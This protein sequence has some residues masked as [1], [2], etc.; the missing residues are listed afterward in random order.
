M[1]KSVDTKAPLGGAKSK[2][3]LRLYP[4]CSS[5]RRLFYVG[6]TH[7]HSNTCLQFHVNWRCV[8]AIKAT[9]VRCVDESLRPPL[10]FSASCRS[11]IKHACM[12]ANNKQ[13][14]YAH[15]QHLA[16][17][18]PSVGRANVPL[19]SNDFPIPMGLRTRV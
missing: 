1:Y 2:S 6:R 19:D 15:L 11:H 13:L 5:N 16:Q 4:H 12:H 17:F 9:G 18:R 8:A 3:W 14:K 7:A 10:S